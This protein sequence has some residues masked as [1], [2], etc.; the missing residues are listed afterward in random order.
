M[1]WATIYQ[2]YPRT[3]LGDEVIKMGLYDGDFDRILEISYFGE[4]PLKIPDRDKIK[5]LQKLP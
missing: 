2:P 1:A 4:S 3:E 5:N